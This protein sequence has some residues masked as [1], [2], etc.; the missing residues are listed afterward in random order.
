MKNLSVLFFT[1]L[2]FTTFAGGG[3]GG[4]DGGPKI[5]LP[6]A[7]ILGGQ[8]IY[9]F[10]VPEKDIFDINETLNGDLDF[11][12]KEV[13]KDKLIDIK[14]LKGFDGNDISPSFIQNL[15]K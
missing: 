9:G 4:S 12:R 15:L 14:T 6:D 10:K 8:D 13:L 1:L 7:R 11:Y 5:K 3:D 2:T